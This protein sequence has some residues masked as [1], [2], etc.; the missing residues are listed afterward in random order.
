MFEVQRAAKNV[1]RPADFLE[2][3]ARQMG[4]YLG[5]ASALYAAGWVV[6]LVLY[7]TA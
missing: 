4:W 2:E 5:G 6:L 7:R 1:E 3:T